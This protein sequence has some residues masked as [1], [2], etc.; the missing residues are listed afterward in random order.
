MWFGVTL[1]V[2][3]GFVFESLNHAVEPRPLVTEK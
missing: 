2:G 3:F 1:V